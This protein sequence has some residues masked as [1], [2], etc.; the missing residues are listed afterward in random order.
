MKI[1]KS[2]YYHLLMLPGM[3]FLIIFS[4]VPMFGLIMAFQ[5]Y[6]PAKGI[7]SSKWVSFD[8]F[9]YIFTIPDSKAVFSNTLIIAISKIILGIVIPVCFALLL[10]EI[11]HKL[12]SK[13]VQTVVYLPHFLSSVVLAPVVQFIFAMDG[14]VNKLREFFG[15]E[16][17][18]SVGFTATF[19][20]RLQWC[21]CGASF[22]GGISKRL[23]GRGGSRG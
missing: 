20:K 4:F 2:V 14:P 6:I 5:K 10:N 8:N 3:I 17:R 18:D 16:M 1:R 11:R 12:F 15:G 23:G 7:F 9:K 19:G 22:M 13:T 21:D